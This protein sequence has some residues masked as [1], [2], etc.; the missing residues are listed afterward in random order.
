MTR[1]F[2]LIEWTFDPLEIKNAYLNIEK[3][4]AIARRYTINQYGITTSPLQGGLPTDR[5]IAE[6]WLKSR[7][8]ENVVARRLVS[9]AGDQQAILVPAPIYEWKASSDTRARAKDVQDHNREQ[10]LC[11][12]AD[13]L[14]VLGYERDDEGNGKF[15]LGNWD[16]DW[17]Y[18]SH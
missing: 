7:R 16:E 5:L 18:A 8:V 2:D 12:F 15:L 13:G 9:A 3:L 6:W 14:A 4:G 1:G 10:F 11:G 17:S